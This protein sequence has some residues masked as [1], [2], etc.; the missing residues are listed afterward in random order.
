MKLIKTKGLVLSFLKYRETSIIVR[1]FTRELG[2]KSYIV[3]GVRTK[4]AKSKMAFYQP[5]TLLDLIVYDKEG[6]GLNRISE[7]KLSKAYERIPFDFQRSSIAMFMGEVLGKSIYE[8]Y[9]NESFYDFL[10]YALGLLDEESVIL[11]HYPL[12]FLWESSKY[13]GFA[14]NNA[15]SFFEELTDEAYHPAEVKEEMDYL[16]GLIGE[17]FACTHKV[18]AIFRKKLL[19][20]FLMFYSK[21]L[22]SQNEWKSVKVL[23]QLL[24]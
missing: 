18:H 17:S 22:E 10:E 24:E 23:R 3:N 9:H 16:D 4:G 12:V 14:P 2:L 11:V 5:L 8:S 15:N 7:V 1:I 21:H 20:H 19:D 13:L 6:A